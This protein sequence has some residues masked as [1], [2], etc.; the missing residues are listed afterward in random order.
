V[1]LWRRDVPWPRWLRRP[2]TVLAAASM[3]ILI[4]H[5][6]FW[7]PLDA[8]LEREVAYVLTIA[9]G[10]AAWVAARLGGWAAQRSRRP[11]P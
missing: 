3:W 10:I 2:V 11:P 5:F 1:L 4:T 8:A 7:P 6:T 9:A